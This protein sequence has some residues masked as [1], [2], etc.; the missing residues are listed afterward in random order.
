MTADL[1]AKGL[2]LSH[3]RL[4]AAL[5]ETE[6]LATV[7]GRL[8]ISQPAASRLLA[9]VEGIG[10][11]AVHRRDGRGIA[12]TEAGQ[13][14]GRRAARI[15]RE[16]NDAAR[17]L[18]EIDSGHTGQVRVGSV[19]GPALSHVM[20]AVRAASRDAPALTVEVEVAASDLL[21]AMLLEG[22]LD[23]ALCRL[24][25]GQDPAL[26]TA[27]PVAPETVD[28]VV[29]DGHPL[30]GGKPTPAQVLQLDW[31]MQGPKAILR[32]T[33]EA[34]LTSLGLPLPRVP[35]STPS[36]LMTLA[37]LQDSDAVAP[38]ARAVSDRFAGAG[39]GFA[40][41]PVDLGIVVPPYAL[42]TRA[43]A[44]LTPAAERLRQMILA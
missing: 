14:L 26:F 11:T 27:Q 15:L 43:G 12:L 42:M 1:T 13:A 2:K 37:V 18:E 9:E 38:L 31:V 4:L 3:L 20:P 44:I 28:L 34:R 40:V 39:S 22:R 29:R 5:T 25:E 33:V 6:H 30:L 19:T 8:G 21:A 23:F 17:E 41:L 7:A 10:G 32:Q 36:F 16:L 35:L 24:P